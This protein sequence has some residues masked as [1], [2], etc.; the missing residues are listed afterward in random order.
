MSR[1]AV[2]ALVV[3]L[4]VTPLLPTYYASLASY[5]VVLAL[6][7]TAINIAI[8]YLGLISFGHAAFF[9]LGAYAAGILNTSLGI[10]FWLSGVIAIIPG[11]CLGAVVGFASL[12][13]QGPYFAIATLA[14]AE[15]M[16]LVA[17]NWVSLTRGPLGII[18]PRPR[19]DFFETLGLTFAQYHLVICLGTLALVLCVLQ[20]LMNS[21]YGR[22]WIALRDQQSLA[23]SVG[24]APLRYRVFA[25]ALS[26]GIAALAG[27]LLVPRILVLSPDLFGV[28]NSATGLLAA[29]LGGRGTLI[30]PLIGGIAFAVAPEFLRV[31]DTYRMVVFACLLLLMVRLRPDGLASLLPIGRA[32][33]AVSPV[34]AAR[35]KNKTSAGDLIITG[36]SRH[37]GGLNAVSDL[38]FKIRQGDILGVIGP[39]GAGK[40]TCLNLISGFVTPNSGVVM[41]GSERLSGQSPARVAA[42]GVVRTFQHTVVCPTLDV[43]ENVLIG[44]HLFSRETPWAAILR[45][46]AFV[47]REAERAAWAD[48]CIETVGLTKRRHAEA[49]SLAYGEQRMLSIA[50][51][52]A[53]QPEFLLLD[54]PGAGLSGTEAL[55]LADLLR[56][57]RDKGITI[58][59]IDHNLRM[60][61]SLCD[62]LVVLHHGEKL[63]EGVPRDVRN[64]PAVVRAYLGE[65]KPG[66]LHAE[67]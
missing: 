24:I 52:L 38:S 49:G 64:E 63:A 26:G 37:F 17:A 62:R 23:E 66:A 56:R 42:R 33:R 50:V 34:P 32:P 60:M 28:T 44:T 8:G 53:A 6:L 12:R 57:L 54:E 41:V 45:T 31:I 48:A 18:V 27:A 10:N 35:L 43:F 36:L 9:G 16:R 13:L 59:I 30:G 14:V 55:A 65:R 47:T 4:G 1:L 3:A 61:M 15:I 46:K 29:I 25:I 51:A 11:A 58:M 19:I 2:F 7:A 67:A 22:A 40:T 5:A 20:R 39:N 21:P